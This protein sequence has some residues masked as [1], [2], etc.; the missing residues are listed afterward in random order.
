[1][2]QL[3][4]QIFL[5]CKIIDLDHVAKQGRFNSIENNR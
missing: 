5:M 1:M 2:I 3:R 4:P